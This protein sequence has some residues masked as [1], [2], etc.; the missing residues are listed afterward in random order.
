ML[1]LIPL[2]RGSSLPLHLLLTK[3]PEQKPGARASSAS[4]ASQAGRSGPWDRAPERAA[5]RG[6][7]IEEKGKS[8]ARLSGIREGKQA[9]RD[10]GDKKG[11]LFTA[12]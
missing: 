2:S 11:K 1:F 10:K 3:S 7:S 6:P 5:K 4:W 9:E 12:C 8:R